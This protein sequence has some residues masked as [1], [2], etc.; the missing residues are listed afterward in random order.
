LIAAHINH[1]S[2]SNKKTLN[3]F[4]RDFKGLSGSATRKKITDEIGMTGATLQSLVKDNDIDIAQ[5]TALLA[6][7]KKYSKPVKPVA[8]GMIPLENLK[9]HFISI[10]VDEATIKSKCA[11][12][13][14]TDGLPYILDVG[15]GIKDDD[16]EVSLITS[17]NFSP[18]IENPFSQL[19]RLLGEVEISDY[20]P[21]LVF[22]HL[23]SPKVSFTDRGKTQADLPNEIYNALNQMIKLVTNDWTKA[24]RKAARENGRLRRAELQKLK[25]NSKPK[26][27]TKTAAYEVMEQAYLKASNNGR[28]PANARQIMYAARP[29]IIEFTGKSK[30]DDAY[31]TQTLLPNFIDENPE[32]TKDWNVAYDARGKFLEPHTGKSIDLGTLGVRNYH[33]S[34][35]NKNIDSTDLRGFSLDGGLIETSGPFNRYKFVLFIEKEDFEHLFKTA[36][37]AEHYDIAIMSTKGMSN[38]ASRELIEHLSKAGVTIFVLHDF[39]KSGFSIAHTLKNNTR[40]YQFDT[41]PN[42]IDIGL[43]LDDVKN[44]ALESEVVEYHEK[45][46]PKPKLRKVGATPEECDFLV[47]GHNG[48]KWHG[49]RVEL[50]AFN[51]AQFINFVE[52]KLLEN[53]VSKVIPEPEKLQMAYHRAAKIVG[54]N[55]VCRKFLE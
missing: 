7:M 45:N 47:S 15:F 3:E 42:V 27:D 48:E 44:F 50:N 5:V 41:T 34:W 8:L 31:F 36:K 10:G 25:D 53:G 33:N 11:K 1:D 43:R 32:L 24:K 39:D 38:T 20:D 22:V 49:K 9:K 2:E 16:S 21:V 35:H 52:S 6:A 23:I 4:L 46:D 28:L 26:I 17:I 51:S 12:E 30:L 29:L 55:Q 40:R 18:L 37:I 19:F 54:L 13:V 14:T